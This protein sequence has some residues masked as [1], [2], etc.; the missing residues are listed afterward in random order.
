MRERLVFKYQL[1]FAIQI[2]R[3]EILQK[4]P[5]VPGTSNHGLFDS[6]VSISQHITQS[7]LCCLSYALKLDGSARFERFH[8]DGEPS[9]TTL[10][11]IH[12]PE[13]T[14]PAYAGHN[15][16]TDVGSLTLL[17]SEQWGLQLLAP[18]TEHWAF[19]EPRRGHAVVNI[20]D[21]LRF[22]SGRRL[23]SALHRVVP[24]N[25][26][27]QNSSRYS[28]AYFL[29]PENG[30]KFVDSD[31]KEVSAQKWH[32]EK[33]VMFGEPHEKQDASNILT[34]GMEEMFC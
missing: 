29:R 17:F 31:G 5:L 11:L 10:G 9:N 30:V 26:G 6:F 27:Y 7:I 34:G 18:K 32:D 19:V 23:C 3:N 24:F 2:P 12:Y 15:K 25:N 16:H 21:S 4:T 1:T 28:I 20:G 8:R 33:Y 13:N 22:L 14:D